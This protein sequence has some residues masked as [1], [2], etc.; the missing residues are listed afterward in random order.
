MTINFVKKYLKLVN[1]GL[2]IEKVPE[3][4]REKVRALISPKKTLS[5]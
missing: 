2:P 1:A 3:K 5:N 4:Y